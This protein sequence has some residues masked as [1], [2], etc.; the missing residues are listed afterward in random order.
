MKSEFRHPLPVKYKE[1]S[2]DCGYRVDLLVENEAIVEL[3][4]GGEIEKRI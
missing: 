3:K 4:A 1:V 2:I